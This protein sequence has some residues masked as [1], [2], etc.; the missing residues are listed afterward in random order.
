MWTPHLSVWNI[1][2]NPSPLPRPSAEKYVH[3]RLGGQNGAREYMTEYINYRT[4]LYLF[5]VP[6]PPPHP[7]GLQCTH[8]P[9]GGK[10]L[11]ASLQEHKCVPVQQT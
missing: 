10:G 4:S 8:A 6:V 1:L 2:G 3:C 7:Q 11:C 5:V 9:L